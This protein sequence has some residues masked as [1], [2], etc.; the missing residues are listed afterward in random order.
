MVAVLRTPDERFSDLPG[1]SYSPRYV[2]VGDT[3]MHYIDQGQGQTVLCLHGEPTWCYLYRKMIPTLSAS[4]RV[5]APDMVGFGRSDK[6]ADRSDYS[7]QMHVDKLTGLIEQLDLRD[8][9]LVCQDWG[10]LIGLRIAAENQER[11]ARLVIMN[12][13]LPTGDEPP[14]EAFLKWRDFAARQ[15]DMPV[16]FILRR[17][18]VQGSALAESVIAAYEAP[19]PDA[20]Y[21]AGAAQFPLLVPIT[22]DDPGSEGMRRTRQ[23]MAQWTKPVQIM[24]SDSDPITAGGDRFFRKLMPAAKS[25]PEITIRGASHFLQEDA[26]QEIAEH[27]L[28]FIDRN[29]LPRYPKVV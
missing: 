18:L 16:G 25:Q 10:G 2:Q 11:F 13:W 17:T 9:T 19:F 28:E 1:F 14:G 21:K 29:P 8:I 23:A 26:G 15:P 24:F 7:F 4:H 3:R 27:I 20:S 12:T 5:V 22:P 6:Y